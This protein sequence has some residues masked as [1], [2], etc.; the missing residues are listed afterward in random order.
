MFSTAV[1]RHHGGRLAGLL[2]GLAILITV[3][4]CGDDHRGTVSRGPIDTL[5][6]G[7]IGSGNILTGPIG[8]ANQR[9]ELI[10]ALKP[11]GVNSVEVFSFPNGPDLNQALIG[12][13]LDVASYGDTPALVARGSGLNTR[14]LAIN[15][16]N[17]DAG[18]VAKAPSIR[19][20]ADL[21]GKR[22]AVQ[23]GSYIDRYLQGALQERNISATLIHL[24]TQDQEAPLSS[25]DIDAAAVPDTLP[26]A[27][28][29]TF[30]RKGFH[31]VDSVRR[32]HIGLAGTSL[33]VSSAEFLSAHP[34]FG[35]AW[36][37]LEAESARYARTHWTD[38][39]NFEIGNS[40]APADAVR[41]AANPD[42]FAEEPFPDAGLSLL[43]GTKKF[44]ADQGNLKRDFS[45]DD[46][47]YHG[48]NRT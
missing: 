10:K 32:D 18:V 4:G 23:K 47:M 16:F 2:I 43:K 28:L 26:A 38:Y 1:R 27:S 17:L 36:Q 15:R 31:L 13:R 8:L 46:W 14:L 40:K 6:I 19:S 48:E 34:E 41:A 37:R 20:L 9:G 21:S 11:L 22:I 39:L 25:G 7:L 45:L 44:L 5:R 12:G 35:A 30:Q 42:S 3:S 33:T 29:Q 24:Y